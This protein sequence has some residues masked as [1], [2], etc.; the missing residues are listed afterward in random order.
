MKGPAQSWFIHAGVLE[1]AQLDSILQTLAAFRTT[2]R[3]IQ[4]GPSQIILLSIFIIISREL[5]SIPPL[6]K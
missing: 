4:A 1:A 5:P 6:G 2:V 3:K